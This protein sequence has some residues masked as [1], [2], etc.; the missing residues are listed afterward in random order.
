[1]SQHTTE[2]PGASPPLSDAT[3]RR[4]Q[5]RAVAAGLVDGPRMRRRF[6]VPAGVPLV[7]SP[8][9][10]RHGARPRNLNLAPRR[11]HVGRRVA[12]VGFLVVQVGALVALLAAPTFRVH[13]VEVTGDRLLSR[14]AVLAAAHVPQ[15][16]LFTVDGD[17]IRARL[18]SLPW[19]RSAVVTTQLPATVSIAVTEWQPELLLRHGADATFVAANGA[20]LAAVR[21]DAAI[22]RG[23][24]VLLDYRPGALQAPMQ[25]L[26]D[27]LAGAARQWP[28]VF[29]CTV[30]AFEL[31]STGVLSIWSSTGWQAVLGTLDTADALAAVPFKLEMLAAL[32]G[33][34]DFIHPTIG[35]VDLENPGAPAT[36]GK[37]GEPASLKADVAG[38]PLPVTAPPSA[39]PAPLAT[40][41]AAPAPTATPAPTPKPTPTP[42]V[43]VLPPPSPSPR[44]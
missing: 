18:G 3:S 25:G 7:A 5:I 43:F 36:G 37:P 31:S 20:T 28:A 29:G 4:A 23:L 24:P 26:A 13:T 21:H 32:R 33:R 22:A 9:R 41:T 12:A 8:R 42:I 15:S 2:R 30:D 11:N 35:Y 38:A 17:A 16:S 19:V 34:V 1:M 40:G 10:R 6:H 44:H 39:E 27:M 14:D